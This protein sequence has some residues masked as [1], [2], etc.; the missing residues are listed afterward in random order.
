MPQV[1]GS[2]VFLEN[3]GHNPQC[4]ERWWQGP[5]EPRFS[6]VYAVSGLI[7][8]ASLSVPCSIVVELQWYDLEDGWHLAKF[9]SSLTLVYNQISE[10]LPRQSEHRP[11]LA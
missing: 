4:K 10:F 5:T 3:I 6:S 7:Y 11:E 2:V 8:L 9:Y 1:M